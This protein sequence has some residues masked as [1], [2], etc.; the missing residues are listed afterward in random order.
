VFDLI[1]DLIYENSAHLSIKKK[2]KLLRFTAAPFIYMIGFVPGFPLPGGYPE[3][4]TAPHQSKKKPTCCRLLQ[5]QWVPG[6]DSR[7]SRLQ[8]VV[9]NR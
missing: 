3:K 7:L 1:P 5:A 8:A 4:L 9:A 2:K 6:H